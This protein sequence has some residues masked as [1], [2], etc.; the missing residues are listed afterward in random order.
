MHEHRLRTAAR[1]AAFIA[2]AL[3]ALLLMSGVHGTAPPSA[4][5]GVPAPPPTMPSGPDFL[6]PPP[7]PVQPALL[8]SAP[9]AFQ[10]A[11]YMAGS[12]TYSVVFVESSGGVGE[13]APP[14]AESEDWDGARRATVLAEIAG[15]LS[16]WTSRTGRPDPL[17]FVVDDHGAQPTS[18]EP[19]S[20]PA[21]DLDLWVADTLTAL[22][23]PSTP[24]DWVAGAYA[25]INDRRAAKATDWGFI[26]FV[27]DSL[28]DGDGVFT[29]GKFAFA[30]LNGPAMVLTYDNDGWGIGNM[31]LV[32]AHETGHIFGALDEYASSSCSTADSWG[33]LN[34]ANDSCN[35]GGDTSDLSIM[36]S[37]AEQLNPAV[38]V[39]DSARRAIG[40][41]NPV[42]SVVDVVR[43]STASV[44]P[45]APDPS[46]DDTPTYSASAGNTAFPPEGPRVIGG[47]DH[48]T[49]AAVSI[50]R[51]AAAEWNLNGGTFTTDGVSPDGGAFDEEL[52]TYIFTPSSAVPN[53]THSFGAR[54]T[55]HFGHVS[56]AATD[57]LT[58]A[59]VTPT[60][61]P[62]SGCVTPASTPTATPT[63]AVTPT[64][65]KQPFPGDT[66]GDGCPDQRENGSDETLGGLRNY[67]NAWDFYDVGGIGGPAPD[68]VVDLLFDVLGVINHYA[69]TGAPPYDAIYDRGPSAGPHPWNMTAPDGAI[70]L[71]NDILGVIRQFDHRCT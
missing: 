44:M 43:T 6:L 11:S 22:G 9:T 10:L 52:E 49:A 59:A 25:F 26:I 24:A 50:S 17:S 21:T 55:N 48:G 65:T 32:T 37:S 13:C 63:P 2:L 34:S 69:P 57:I 60:P 61:C 45:Y 16:F 27:V 38:D 18:C 70:D 56:D 14:D 19:I 33:Y 39:S 62:T 41:R 30:F 42:G 12:A 47:G 67:M 3:T 5:A 15:G 29:D 51:V 31:D 36:G 64:P 66:D 4:S 23:Y 71:L 53:G 68:G 8:G 7:A 1:A 46:A 20:R 54:S 35:N 40:W 28:N 58:I